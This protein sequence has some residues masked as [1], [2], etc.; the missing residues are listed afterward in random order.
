VGSM[1]RGVTQVLQALAPAIQLDADHGRVPMRLLVGAR[2]L[3]SLPIRR[4][5]ETP[6]LN[7]TRV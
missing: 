2:L 7:P 6:G 1:Q 4:K 3:H 5:P